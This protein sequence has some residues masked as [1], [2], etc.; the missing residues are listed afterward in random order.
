[1]NSVGSRTV[2]ITSVSSGNGSWAAH[3][4]AFETTLEC[5]TCHG[6]RKDFRIMKFSIRSLALTSAIL[7]GLAMLAM[8]VAIWFGAITASDSWRPCRRYTPA[9]RPLVTLRMLSLGPYTVSSMVSSAVQSLP[10]S[11]TGLHGA[12]LE[13]SWELSKTSQ[14]TAS[15]SVIDETHRNIEKCSPGSWRRLEEARCRRWGCL[16]SDQLGSVKS[17]HTSDSDGSDS[18]PNVRM[19]FS[20]TLPVR[21]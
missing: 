8:G 21:R 17:D 4:A 9:T 14:L 6:V 15:N 13:Q 20:R 1:M 18:V 10:G 3:P 19:F 2:V 11:I 16:L 7:W 5:C 12:V